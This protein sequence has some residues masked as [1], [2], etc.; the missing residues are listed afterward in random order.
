L[1]SAVRQLTFFFA[2]QTNPKLVKQ[3]VNDTMILPPLVLHGANYAFPKVRE[4]G[5]GGEGDKKRTE[6]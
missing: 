1:E 5:E 4:R 2:K 6:K 3:E